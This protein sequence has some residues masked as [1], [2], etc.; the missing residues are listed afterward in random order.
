MPLNHKIKPGLNGSQ[1]QERT[2]LIKLKKLELF[3]P[4]FKRLFCF[5]PPNNGPFSAWGLASLINWLKHPTKDGFQWLRC[6]PGAH[7]RT[8]VCHRDAFNL[9]V[10]E[11]DQIFIKKNPLQQLDNFVTKFPPPPKSIFYESR[12][13]A[14]TLITVPARS[15]KGFWVFCYLLVNCR[16]GVKMKGTS[17][18]PRVSRSPGNQLA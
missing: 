7:R 15:R 13:K 2:Q 4:S 1:C 3:F 16:H 6:L 5:F 8:V 9:L 12:C 17:V 18:T 11:L 14:G 10:K